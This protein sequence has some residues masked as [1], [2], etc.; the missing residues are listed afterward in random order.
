MPRRVEL[1]QR[2]LRVAQQRIDIVSR[3]G[4]RRQA[5]LSRGGY[6]CRRGRKNDYRPA[7]KHT[8]NQARQV[9]RSAF[10]KCKG[11]APRLGSKGGVWARSGE[12]SLVRHAAPT[13][14]DEVNPLD[15]AFVSYSRKQ[16]YFAESLV[17]ALQR[18]GIEIWFDLQQLAPGTAWSEG[19]KEGAQ[20]C[21]RLVL[22][23]SQ[24]AI[25]SPHVKAEWETVLDQGRE[26]IVVLYEA[27]ELP[28]RLRACPIYD[29]RVN[30]DLAIAA[31]AGYLQGAQPA[32]HDALPKVERSLLWQYRPRDVSWTAG[33]FFMPTLAM[34]MFA[35]F[36]ALRV[37]SSPSEEWSPVVRPLLLLVGLLGGWFKGMSYFPVG[38]LLRHDTNFEKL[39]ATGGRLLLFWGAAVATL[40]LVCYLDAE[41]RPGLI[42]AGIG[43]T[44]MLLI[45]LRWYEWTLPK[46]ADLL[47]WLPSG[48]ADEE[49]RATVQAAPAHPVA[50]PR[51][52]RSRTDIRPSFGYALH[53]HPA[54]A[55]IAEAI[56]ATLKRQ[57]CRAT[58]AA[59][60][61][62]QLI[63][64]SNRTSIQ[65]LLQKNAELQG[66]VINILVTNIREL[67]ELQSVF[68]RQWVD[69]RSGR[70]ATIQSMAVELADVADADDSYASQVS[71]TGFNNASGFPR[72]IQGYF[73]TS[74][75]LVIC[76]TLVVTRFGQS[77]GM[78]TL[79][80]LPLLIPYLLH[81][82]GLITRSRPL[83]RGRPGL[84][85][86]ASL[87]WFAA[88]AAKAADPIGNNDL[89]F[90]HFLLF[91]RVE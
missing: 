43:S 51:V 44:L 40:G 59:G 16:L 76:V 19:L 28:E 91:K 54:D 87:V 26:V 18:S 32:R 3:G 20:H 31:L 89:R 88:P 1:S 36:V 7:P 22:I 64:V 83:G 80:A 23:A 85:Q 63:L 13:R 75:V 25:A 52:A 61:E 78:Q 74:A 82:R 57:G 70:A 46:S 84:G 60:A 9:T 37:S 33:L 15:Y 21:G 55:H 4:S 68:Q 42:G 71:P 10:S 90:L 34:C 12:A 29:A 35:A 45:S 69:F 73:R 77:E 56:G 86:G 5:A 24:A 50:Q 41:D 65:W 66:R 48:A 11:R 2:L 53:L 6:P 30:F 79:L 62:V 47:R 14:N 8:R 49:V 67:P 81:V 58:D 27:V 39:R 38:E 17:L 72:S